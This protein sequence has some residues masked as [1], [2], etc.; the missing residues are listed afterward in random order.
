M[1]EEEREKWEEKKPVLTMDAY[2]C[3]HR[4]RTQTTWT[5]LAGV[6]GS[7]SHNIIFLL[8]WEGSEEYI[9]NIH[10]KQSFLNNVC[11][12]SSKLRAGIDTTSFSCGKESLHLP[13][14]YGIV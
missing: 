4:W 7:P 9:K 2:E 12:F 6:P 3:H 13:V 10:F 14:A 8:C 5:N 1:H 11:I